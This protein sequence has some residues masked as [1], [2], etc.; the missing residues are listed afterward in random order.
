MKAATRRSSG[1]PEPGHP[2]TEGIEDHI[3]LEHGEM[4]GEFFDVPEPLETIFISSFTGGEVFR[5]GLTYQRGLGSIFYFRPGHETYP[6]YHNPQILRVIS[7][8]VRWASPNMPKGPI[9]FGQHKQGWLEGKDRNEI[10]GH[11]VRHREQMSNEQPTPLE[12]ATPVQPQRGFGHSSGF[13]V[14]FSRP[15]PLGDVLL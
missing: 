5:S 10:M 8:A 1:S 11:R 6:T 13:L 9:K 2:I 12:Y 15:M 14:A 4:Y 3:I 7:N